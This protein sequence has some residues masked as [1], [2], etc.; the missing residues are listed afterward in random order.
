MG[1]TFTEY[2]VH[3]DL[4]GPPRRVNAKSTIRT[5]SAIC[6]PGPPPALRRCEFRGPAFR[7]SHIVNG[8]TG[9]GSGGAPLP[10]FHSSLFH[11]PY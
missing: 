5:C 7:K 6:G 9:G 11:A 10:Q 2:P 1:T 8:G 4:S 3:D